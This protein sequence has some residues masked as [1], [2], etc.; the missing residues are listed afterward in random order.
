MIKRAFAVAV[1]A[2]LLASAG[3]PIAAAPKKT[4]PTRA[5]SASPDSRA[6]ALVRRMTRDEK[7]ILVFGYFG[8]DNA[9]KKFIAPKESLQGSAG[10]VPGIPRLGIPP[11]WQT[12]AGVGVATQGG[13]K[14]KRERTAL[15]SG[16]A[17]AATWNTA[18]AFTGGAMIGKEARNTGFNGMLALHGVG[19]FLTGLILHGVKTSGVRV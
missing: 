16:L 15:P 6:A 17:T 12:D 9:E 18:L 14:V 10:Y 7:L 1:T 8:T 4:K 2:A 19:G 3:A 5:V 11:Q 13:A